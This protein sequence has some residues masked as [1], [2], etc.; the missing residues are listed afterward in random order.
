V[1]PTA[2]RP[3]GAGG[4]WRV[5]R[6]ALS[7]RA[8]RRRPLPRRGPSAPAAR[9]A[10]SGRAAARTSGAA[11][12]RC[13]V[14]P[15]PVAPAPLVRGCGPARRTG[16]HR[17]AAPGD[18]YGGA[19]LG[20]RRK[21]RHRGGV[22]GGAADSDDPGHG[23]RPRLR[24]EAVHVD[25]R[26]A[27]DR[28]G[29]AGAGGQGLLVPAR[30]RG[31]GQTGHHPAPPAHA[32]LR[33]PFLAPALQGADVRGK[34]PARVER[35]AAEPARLDVSVLGPEP[36]LA[37]ARPGEDHRSRSGSAAPRRDHRSARD[38]PYALQPAGLLAAA[39]RGD[40]GR[41]SALVGS[42]PGAGVGRGARRERL[43][44]RRGRGPR[45]CLLVRLGPG[46]PLPHAA[47]RGCVRHDPHP[48]PRVGGADVHRLQHLVPR[49]RA[50]T[51]LRALPALVHGRDGHPAH[52][53]PHRLH[54]HLARPGPEHRLLPR[55]AR[56]LR[57]SGARLAVRIRAPGGRGEP[58]RPGRPRSPGP[59]PHVLVLRDGGR[60]HGDAGA[61]AARH[62][63]GGRTAA[64]PALRPV[65]GPGGRRPSRPH[66][67]QAP[68]RSIRPG[69]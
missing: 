14:V 26:G 58:P 51:G 42:G 64:P 10:R 47:R 52:G 35:G 8:G 67:A 39:H 25:P 46:R 15:R 29:R 50:R 41:P 45:R 37:A 55:G 57:P 31:R 48:D 36:D 63:R 38:G 69:R 33:V 60:H 5:R 59:R 66:G 30:V 21:D 32:H 61:P 20:V 28:A 40:R 18:R 56:Q 4:R 3:A 53:G 34:A 49:R 11:R 7:G 16:R 22:P 17:R 9:F 23:L 54:R 13:R 19:V 68:P 1:E 2:A 27:A 12:R 44:P 24:V 6:A 65:V 43:R 62:R